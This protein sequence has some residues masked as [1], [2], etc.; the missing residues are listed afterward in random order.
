[1]SR[2]PDHD[3][4][5]LALLLPPHIFEESQA[6]IIEILT[7][8]ANGGVPS[9]APVDALIKVLRQL[10][11]FENQS[12]NE[13]VDPITRQAM[14]R[15][16]KQ[17]YLKAIR[18]ALTLHAAGGLDAAELIADAERL[19]LG[20]QRDGLEESE[21]VAKWRELA[22]VLQEKEDLERRLGEQVVELEAEEGLR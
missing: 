21:K 10:L 7:R 19:K 11:A 12:L 16:R 3:D 17:G 1:M 5:N 13:L 20:A 22:T 8:Y 9:V 2:T 18:K 14:S 4:H 15:E 6:A